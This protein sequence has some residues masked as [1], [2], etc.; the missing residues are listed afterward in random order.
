MVEFNFVINL[1]DAHKR[2]CMT[3]AAVS[4]KL[5]LKSDTVRRF[6]RQ[7]NVE[8]KQLSIAVPLMCDFYGVDFH[9]AVKIRKECK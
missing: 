5:G 3:A 7:D 1:A 8:V 9:D 4:R 6:T 2:K